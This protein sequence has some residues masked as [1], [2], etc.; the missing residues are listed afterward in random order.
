MQ[1][2]F[3][4]NSEQSFVVLYFK[5]SYDTIIFLS[6]FFTEFVN[7]LTDPVKIKVNN[8]IYDK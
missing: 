6:L 4:G 7:F 5:N 1:C 8:F 3:F 2:F